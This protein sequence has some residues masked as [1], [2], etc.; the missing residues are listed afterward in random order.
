MELRLMA[1][2]RRTSVSALIREKLG[3]KNQEASRKDVWKRLE[4]F[5]KGVTQK[6]PGVSL[7]QKLV[8]MRY[9]Q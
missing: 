7:S 9:E 8:E 3:A 6:N 5:A 4:V 1:A 2:R